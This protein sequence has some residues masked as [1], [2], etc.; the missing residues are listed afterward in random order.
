MYNAILDYVEEIFKVMI[1]ANEETV[2]AAC[3][4]LVKMTPLPMNTMLEKQSK[5]EALQKS[6]QCKEKVPVNIPPTGECKYMNA[7]L[8]NSS[9]STR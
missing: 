8:V 1:T 4:A 3:H 7:I 9:P 2:E 6:Y 5:E